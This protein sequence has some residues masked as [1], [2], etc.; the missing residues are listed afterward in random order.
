MMGCM[1]CP[2]CGDELQIIPVIV[3]DKVCKR[4][5]YA[6]MCDGCSLVSE[7]DYSGV[8]SRLVDLGGLSTI[9]FVQGNGVT[10]LPLMR[11]AHTVDEDWRES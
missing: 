7:V 3:E 9:D 6:L 1:P 4:I 8:P 5:R 11:T 2:V 10:L